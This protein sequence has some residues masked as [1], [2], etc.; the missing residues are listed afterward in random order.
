[1]G[2]SDVPNGGLTDVVCHVKVFDPEH[3]CHL[4]TSR[5]GDVTFVYEG[6]LNEGYTAFTLFKV[7]LMCQFPVPKLT[8][9][10]DTMVLGHYHPSWD[11]LHAV[12]DLCSG[13]GGL[14]Q[15][16]IATGFDVV[17]AVD[18][19]QR[20][21][22]LH[23]KIHD[24]H[25]I[26]GDFGER[27][28]ILETWKNSRGASVITAGFSCQPYSRLGDGKSHLDTR[29]SCLTKAL[30]AA[31]FLYSSVIILECVAPAAHDAFVNAEIERFCRCTGF[32]CSQTEL[33][34][35]QIWPCRRHRSWWVI[36]APL[37][38]SID[39]TSW[40]SLNNIWEVQQVIPRICLWDANDEKQL[41]LDE[42]ELQAFG[43]NEN[44]HA[45]HMLNE[46]SV[47]P[48]ALHAWGSQTRA[49]PCGCR[50]TGFSCQRLES[51]GLHGCIVR[52][53]AMHDGTTAFRHLHPNE[54]MALNTMDPV[55]DLGENVRLTLSAVG[56]IAC[57]IQ[58]SWIFGFIAA[59]LDAMKQIPVFDANSQM[60]AYRSWI[61]MRCRQVWPCDN[62][63]VDDP[64][65][66]AMVQFWSGYKDLSLAELLYPMRWDGKIEGNV[67][68]ASILDHIIRTQEQVPATVGDA[69]ASCSD[70]EAT[71]WYDCPG[72]VDDPT[73]VGCIQADSCTVIFEGSGDSP[74][75]FQPKC[76]ATVAQFLAAQSK[77]V[78]GFHV[79]RV[80]LNGR[81]ITSEHVMEVGQ[82]IHVQAV[83]TPDEVSEKCVGAERV[84]SPTAQWT[85]PIQDP[86]EI[87]SPPRKVSKFDVG[88]C[89]LPSVN[90]LDQAWLDASPFLSLHGDQ[91][92]KLTAPSIT[93]VQQLW[94][95]RH[96]FFR[97][98]DRVNILTAQGQLW[99]DDEIRFHLH[100]LT[101]VHRDHQLKFSKEMI[102]VRVI[103]PLI[104]AAWV[105]GKGFDCILWANDH[106]E[107]KQ[108]SMLLITA[109]LCG[110]HWIPVLMAPV[111]DV[112]QV[113][114]W[115]GQDTCHEVV[116]SIIQRLA[117]GLGFNDVLFQNNH[118]SFPTFDLCGALAIAF[119]RHVLV[120][121]P[122]PAD[123]SEAM[124]VHAM[125]RSVFVQTLQRCQI[126]DRPWV[127]GAGDRDD[128]TE[129][130][131][132]NVSQPPMVNVT[133][134]ERIDLINSNGMAMA[135]DEVRFHIINLV[136]QQRVPNPLMG[137]TFVYLEPLVFNCWSSIGK[138]IAEKWCSM[139]MDVRT[140][141]KNIVTAFA[142]E[143]HWVPL[144]F[145]P[146]G[147]MLQ[148]HTFQNALDDP[149]LVEEIIEFIA[150]YLDFRTSAIH[151]IREGLPEHEMCGAHAMA[152][153]AHV[154]VNM[155][156][157]ETI[158]DLRTLHTNMR[159]S[160]VAHLYS[161]EETPRPVVWGKG[162]K[163]PKLAHV[164]STVSPVAQ[165]A[166]QLS[167]PAHG[168][169]VH[170]SGALS[171]PSE[172]GL[173]QEMPVPL[174]PGRVQ[175]RRSC[176]SPVLVQTHAEAVEGTMHEGALVQPLPV[177][178]S[179][180]QSAVGSSS[181]F[182]ALHTHVAVQVSQHG[183]PVGAVTLHERET[184]LT[185]NS[186]ASG[187]CGPL[188]KLP[189][190]QDVGLTRVHTPNAREA[191]CAADATSCDI[192]TKRHERL[193]QIT[194]HGYAIADD[195]MYFQLKHLL[196]CQAQPAD[197]QF[198]VLPPIHVI[199]WLRG[200]DV[201]FHAWVEEH[202][203]EIMGGQHHVVVV[204]LLEMHWIPV[205]FAPVQGGMHAH[206]LSDFAADEA[207]VD[208]V[209]FHIVHK[210][211]SSLLL[212][213]RVP[214]GI[215]TQKLCG[216]MSISFLAHII[217]GTNL[218]Q[219]ND[220]LYERCWSMKQV[221]ADAIAQGPFDEP[222]E[223]GLSGA[224]VTHGNPG[225]SL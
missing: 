163:E 19:N 31:Y 65:L 96:Q 215:Q 218:P 161:I 69:P 62:D 79:T 47:A 109:F 56:Q 188:P 157:P 85:Q 145:A 224:G 66:R 154:I 209:L 126:T 127:W 189:V 156:L 220:D 122:I 42:K 20:M 67:S 193:L 30:N 102:Q 181:L 100:A 7:C 18:Q 136:N 108:K 201:E 219:T 148:V 210:F 160:F 144:W 71:P 142:V 113:T 171:C 107:V 207:Q 187:E 26:C 88:S 77:L 211:G 204:L 38:G 223:W 37:I 133:R 104:A 73:T 140:Q 216:V 115:D 192:E 137:R 134:D 205:W 221:F 158:E 89:T 10:K 195:E 97:T 24:A 131:H 165:P 124:N 6:Y 25:C 1:M 70:E 119:L 141:G 168:R 180:A 52:S 57:P 92:L 125:L 5:T 105:D 68:I 194:S 44:T 9:T 147:N 213:H 27:E 80:T 40:P 172:Q 41:A 74:I 94:S 54:A 225:H 146:R 93:N 152:F 222:T 91:F 191:G 39:L 206:T 103:D 179:N 49:C 214:H 182:H 111:Q 176:H 51:K 90:A 162:P 199:Q 117:V 99:A 17:T 8:A 23:A 143:G 63:P 21:L 60:Q 112:L 114:T 46:K 128:G 153:L 166:S 86:I 83:F 184:C 186:F 95:V 138:V 13:F 14:A 43:V 61:L 58:A 149:T 197:R 190:T 164:H 78:G 34:L 53:A 159:A 132:D 139:N 59:K 101:L 87:T 173:P 123:Q 135:D 22:D 12:I 130:G 32:H 198:L 75:R 45:R 203:L 175:T 183:L 16:A 208:Q 116:H 64:K 106:P 178:S 3:V 177:G 11:S 72:I 129:T 55:L 212:I 202:R 4:L 217:L 29:A 151:R 185:G 174:P 155:Q 48:C 98:D 167:Q 82:C 2:F 200:N 50:S 196:E 118:R 28:I 76:D 36:T 120:G 150:D 121:T 81:V 35:D 15:G 33:K 110:K 170:D 169:S 84:V